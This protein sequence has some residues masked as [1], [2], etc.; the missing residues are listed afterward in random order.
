[1]V[2]TMPEDDPGSLSAQEYADVL[3]YILQLNDLPAGGVELPADPVLLEAVS[4][5]PFSGEEE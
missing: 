3:A 5:A 4:L 2:E 1:M